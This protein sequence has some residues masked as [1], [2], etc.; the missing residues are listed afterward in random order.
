MSPQNKIS[1]RLSSY[2]IL[3]RRETDL[4]TTTT[5]RRQAVLL[6]ISISSARDA[7]PWRTVSTYLALSLHLY[8]NLFVLC[9]VLFR[10]ITIAHCIFIQYPCTLCVHCEDPCLL[11]VIYGHCILVIV[12]HLRQLCTYFV[13]VS[14]CPF[15]KLWISLIIL[16]N[17]RGVVN[18]SRQK[19]WLIII[20]Q[21]L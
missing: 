5:S 9:C 11:R 12:D 4:V 21:E 14:L 19:R 1:I 16:F 20:R 8:L 2:F 3:P 6:R 13:C 15:G 7:L 17:S 18:V 10:V